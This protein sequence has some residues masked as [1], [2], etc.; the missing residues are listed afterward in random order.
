MPINR[1]RLLKK[2]VFAEIYKFYPN[3]G[4]KLRGLDTKSDGLDTKLNGLDTKLNGLDTKLNGLDAF[5]FVLDRVLI[6]D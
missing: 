5:P 1:Y 2:Q 6:S 3:F 4:I